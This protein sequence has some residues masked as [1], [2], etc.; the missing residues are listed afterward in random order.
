M[1][2]NL[3]KVL[4]ERSDKGRGIPQTISVDQLEPKDDL[5]DVGPLPVKDFDSNDG[6]LTVAWDRQ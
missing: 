5:A 3:T 6:W 2:R 4:T 1:R